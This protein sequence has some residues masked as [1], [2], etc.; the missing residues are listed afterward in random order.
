MSFLLSHHLGSGSGR[1]LPKFLFG[2]MCFLQHEER[3]GSDPGDLCQRAFIEVMLGTVIFSVSG[4]VASS[5][6]PRRR[7]EQVTVKGRLEMRSPGRRSEGGA[8]DREGRRCAEL[9]SL[10]G[11]AGKQRGIPARWAGKDPLSCTMAL[12][13]KRPGSRFSHKC[14]ATPL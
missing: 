2:A 9:D 7:R 13:Q 3:R 12:N 1:M 5:I 4:K 14:Q 11:R 8:G 6:R 10:C